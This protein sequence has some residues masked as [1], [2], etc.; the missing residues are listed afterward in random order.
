[1]QEQHGVAV[2]RSKVGEADV[3]PARSRHNLRRRLGHAWSLSRCPWR[4]TVPASAA[5][6]LVQTERSA[7]TEKAV[8]VVGYEEWT[9]DDDGLIGASSGHYDADEYARQLTQGV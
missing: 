6:L 2:A 3:G 8:R 1:V 9:I 5:G 7:G 4:T